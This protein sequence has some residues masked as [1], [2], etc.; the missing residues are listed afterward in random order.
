MASSSDRRDNNPI[1]AVNG[2]APARGALKCLVCA[3]SK[4]SDDIA[5]ARDEVRW[6][7]AMVGN[8]V[9]DIVRVHD[10]KEMARVAKHRVVICDNTFVSESSEAADRL[11]DPSHVRNYSQPEWHSFFELAGL[12][13]A[14]ERYLDRPLEIEAG[15]PFDSMTLSCMP[16]GALAEPSNITT[17]VSLPT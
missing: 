3:P 6:F 1:D 15:P 7:P 8:H 2:P 12:E 17:S 14:D 13:L 4:V 16:L 10:V 5:A 11:R 9:A